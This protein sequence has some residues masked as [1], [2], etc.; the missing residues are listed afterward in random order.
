MLTYYTDLFRQGPPLHD[1]ICW[2]VVSP[3]H[4][5]VTVDDV[6]A[7]LTGSPA[8]VVLTPHPF[9][10]AYDHDDRRILHLRHIG[11]SVGVLEVNGG[12][13]ALS[14]T[15][16][17]LSAGTRVHTAF[18]NIKSNSIMAYA[19]S[20]RVHVTFEALFPEQRTGSDPT[21]LDG[22]LGPLLEAL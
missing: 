9:D 10:A 15:L 17:R 19:Q 21:A 8:P 3:L 18:W 4:G 2:T 14:P 16:E 22:H 7:R 12:L 11:D 5:P 1:G 20:G 13:T 6:A